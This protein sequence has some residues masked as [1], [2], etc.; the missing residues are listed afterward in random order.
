M[1]RAVALLS[2]GLDSG[3]A[4]VLWRTAGN[5]LALALTAD[6]GQRAAR[7]ELTAAGRLAKRFGVPWRSLEL[8][9]LRD[10]AALAGSALIA[11]GGPLPRGTAARPGDAASAQA[12]W[13]PARNV[14]LLAAAAAF[15][16]ALAAECVLAGFNR[17]EA[18]TF[19]DNSSGFVHAMT[20]AL[21]SGTRR[22]V[23]VESPTIDM[24]KRAIA[25]AASEQG[26]A[27][28]D[29][30]S[31]YEAGPAPC[32]TCESCARSERAFTGDR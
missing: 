31:C 8:P 23:T 10:A 16:E 29:F 11:G 27:P 26:L 14:V 12:V 32:G 18:A 5:D 24:D 17:E 3:T 19:A 28:S 1:T 4:M 25:A 21:A 2:G 7:A 9:W 22:G 13:V 20:R 30:W 6:Y 15:A